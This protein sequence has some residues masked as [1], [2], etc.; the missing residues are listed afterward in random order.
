MPADFNGKWVLETSENFEDYL[1]ALSKN[2]FIV[3]DSMLLYDV[4][5]LR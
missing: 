1:K 2:L 4:L 5:F 3:L